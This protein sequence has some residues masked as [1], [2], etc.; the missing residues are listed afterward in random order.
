VPCSGRNKAPLAEMPGMGNSANFAPLSRG[1]IVEMLHV[2]NA[3]LG[4]GKSVRA[5]L[6]AGQGRAAGDLLLALSRQA[7]RSSV[8]PATVDASA[9]TTRSSDKFHDRPIQTR[10]PI[11]SPSG[12]GGEIEPKKR[13]R[14]PHQDRATGTSHWRSM[15]GHEGQQPGPKSSR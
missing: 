5:H 13:L 6:R 15:Q 4:P 8:F 1:R 2:S 3:L 11:R 14:D 12:I 9:A 7:F 10:M